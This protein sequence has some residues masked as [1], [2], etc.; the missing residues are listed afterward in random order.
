MP[1]GHIAVFTYRSVHKNLLD[2]T[3]CKIHLDSGHTKN[4][5]PKQY[6]LQNKSLH[7]LHKFSSKTECIQ[8]G[9][10]YMST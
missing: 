3:N 9:Y 5:M 8:V 10:N 2:G 1:L 7:G 4:F 6:Y